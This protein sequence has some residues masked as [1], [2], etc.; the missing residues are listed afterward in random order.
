MGSCGFLT[1]DLLLSCSNLPPI[2]RR[3]DP[4]KIT[5]VRR[6]AFDLISFPRL[7]AFNGRL[8]TEYVLFYLV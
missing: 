3:I 2:L 4:S 5:Q 7:N 8:V 6:E 1:L